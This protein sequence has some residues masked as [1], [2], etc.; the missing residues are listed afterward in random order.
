MYRSLSY[1]TWW[2]LEGAWLC[3]YAPSDPGWRQSISDSQWRS[4]LIF[5]AYKSWLRFRHTLTHT[6]GYKQPFWCFCF[7]VTCVSMCFFLYPAAD[8]WRRSWS[9]FQSRPL[10]EGEDWPTLWVIDWQG[11]GVDSFCTVC[12]SQGVSANCQLWR[13]WG[14]Q[15]VQVW[16]HFP[17][18]WTGKKKLARLNA[19]LSV[20]SV[21]VSFSLSSVFLHNLAVRPL[22]GFSE[23]AW[24][25]KQSL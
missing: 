15:H 12:V 14:Q 20:H 22:A 9:P 7:F 21:Y 13:T 24:Q 5:Q 19:L 17:M 11:W 10:P 2:W 3:F 16:S 25:N 6:H 23:T 1:G 4:C 18:L 8:V